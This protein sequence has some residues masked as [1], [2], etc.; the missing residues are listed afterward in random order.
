MIYMILRVLIG[1]EMRERE[2]LMQSYP[3]NLNISAMHEIKAGICSIEL[4]E[5]QNLYRTVLPP[6]TL[7]YRQVLTF[8]EE[9][10]KGQKV[11]PKSQLHFGE[12]ALATSLVCIRWGSYFGV[13]VHSDLPQWISAYDPEEGCI[14][15][16]EMAR[17]NIEATVSLAAWINLMHE[18]SSYFRIDDGNDLR[19]REMD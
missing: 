10:S 17:I 8:L 18:D 13:L 12:V 2:R 11:P 19:H 7:M 4:D 14:S 1:Y 6:Q 16:S 9:A 15:D 5:K 3:P